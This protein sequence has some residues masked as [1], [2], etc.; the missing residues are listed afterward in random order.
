MRINC[1]LEVKIAEFPPPRRKAVLFGDSQGLTES[2]GSIPN[3]ATDSLWFLA[4]TCSL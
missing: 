2:F 4:V 1:K 3:F